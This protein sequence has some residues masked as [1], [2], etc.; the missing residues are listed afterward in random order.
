MSTALVTELVR[1]F[2]KRGTDRLISALRQECCF[3]QDFVLG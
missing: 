2:P 3:L 1:S